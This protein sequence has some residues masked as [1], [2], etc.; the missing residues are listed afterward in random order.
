MKT[1][2]LVLTVILA[3]LALG[4]GFAGTTA[5]LYVTQP[6]SN[7][8]TT[9]R[10][11]VNSGDSTQVV[12]QHLQ[13]DGLS[14]SALAFRLYARLEHLDQG[15][16]PGVYLLNPNMT[17]KSIIAALQVGKPDEQLAG[18]PDALRV[19]QYPQYFTSLPNFNATTF[20]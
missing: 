20:T 3:H 5:V 10:F 7:S 16:E 19:T 14:R 13:D 6:T 8:T 9:V 17:M 11:I 2:G 4:V 12:A 15:I 18:V 1:A